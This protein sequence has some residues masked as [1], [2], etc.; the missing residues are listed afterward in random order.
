MQIKNRI[1]EAAKDY[2]GTSKT[3]VF[4]DELVDKFH[5]ELLS[6]DDKKLLEL[7]FLSNPTQNEL[8]DFLSQ[9]DIEVAGGHKALM[10]SYFMKMHPELKFTKYEQPRLAGLLNFY[11]FQ[12]LELIAHYTTIGR[13]LNKEKIPVMILKGGAMKY[14]RKGLS[15]VMGDIDILVP[16]KDYTRSGK[17]AESMGYHSSWFEHSVDLHKPGSKKGTLDIHQYIYMGTGCEKKLNSGLFKRATKAN[18]FGVDSL[19]PCNEDMFFIALINMAKNLAENTSSTGI[20]Y[21]LFDCK[22]LLETK[23]DFNW[24]IVIENAIKTKTQV[25]LSFAIKFINKIIPNLLPNKVKANNLLEKEINNHC[26]LVLYERFYLR[27]IRTKCRELKIL[28]VL[29][30]RKL[31]SEYI[32]LKPKYFLLKQLRKS[33]ASVKFIFKMSSETK[34][35]EK[36]RCG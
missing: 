29:K 11:R 13:A 36:G 24:D 34:Q 9:W 16:E 3:D 26:A 10:L 5:S 23:P 2:Q 1:I 22:F 14:I 12:N 32:E 20:L 31:L 19:I 18:V 30:N 25:H 7:T 6:S 17:I 35:N 27:D 8:D 28:N 4:V 21:A 33:P 15:R